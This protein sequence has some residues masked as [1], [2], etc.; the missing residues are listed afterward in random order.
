MVLI[1]DKEKEQIKNRA[2]ILWQFSVEPLER[3]LVLFQ[4]L[5]DFLESK[6][7]ACDWN[8]FIPES[9]KFKD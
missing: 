1:T 5:K 9:R 4:A 3:E 6:G 7:V 8:I 2:R